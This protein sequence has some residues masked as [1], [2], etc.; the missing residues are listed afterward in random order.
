MIKVKILK[1][2][3]EF[4]LIELLNTYYLIESCFKVFLEFI[5]WVLRLLMILS[6]WGKK[7]INLD[8]LAMK[9]ERISSSDAPAEGQ[10]IAPP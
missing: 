10:R 9:N 6:V 1:N 5:N 7:Y 4:L 3:L 8:G 2:I